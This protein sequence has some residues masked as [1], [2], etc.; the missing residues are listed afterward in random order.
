MMAAGSHDEAGAA[1]DLVVACTWLFGDHD[2]Q[3]IAERLA[4]LGFDGVEV[5]ADIM[6]CSPIT[7]RHLYADAGL[8]VF[9]LTPENVDIAH[10]DDCQRDHAVNYYERLIEF[11]A[12]L[13][14][15]RVTCHEAVGRTHPA[16]TIDAEW[17]RLV[18]SCRYL[19]E[20]AADHDISLIFEPLHRGLV[21]Q[22]HRADEVCHLLDAVGHPALSIVLDTYHLCLEE[23]DPGAAIQRCGRHVTAVQLGDTDR[24]PLGTGTAP[25]DCCLIGLNDIGFNGPWIL[26][27]TTQLSGPSLAPGTIDL[28]QVER[29]L[30]AS[31]QWLQAQWA[32]IKKTPLG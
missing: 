9:S 12:E 13:G 20:V 31:W 30:A 24:R 25:L 3:H 17:S 22:I 32:A 1:R 7:L 26:E 5:L 6:H 27:C 16:D 23:S 2:H 14:C 10:V 11:A 29:E 19:A 18:S 15:P 8:S 28:E 21:S 4:R